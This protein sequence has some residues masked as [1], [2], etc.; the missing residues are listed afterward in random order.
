MVH[1]DSGWYCLQCGSTIMDG[2]QGETEQRKETP[3]QTAS[4]QA[5]SLRV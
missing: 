5:P 1:S 3:E 2:S 4:A